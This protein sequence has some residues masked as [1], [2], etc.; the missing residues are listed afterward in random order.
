M[1]IPPAGLPPLPPPRAARS[2]VSCATSTPFFFAMASKAFRKPMMSMFFLVCMT[3]MN[4]TSESAGWNDLSTSPLPLQR[5][6]KAALFI[7]QFPDLTGQKDSNMMVRASRASVWEP[8]AAGRLLGRRAATLTDGRCE[9]GDVRGAVKAARGCPLALSTGTSS[10]PEACA[11]CAANAACAACAASSEFPGGGEPHCKMAFSRTKMLWPF[12]F[13]AWPSALWNC[14]Q[15]MRVWSFTATSS[16]ISPN[17]SAVSTLS[18]RWAAI[19]RSTKPCRSRPGRSR[20]KLLKT[21]RTPSAFIAFV[22][23]PMANWP[24]TRSP[25]T[26]TAL[27]GFASGAGAALATIFWWSC[28]RSTPFFR[29]TKSTSWANCFW[30]T[31]LPC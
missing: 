20:Q 13:A 25:D 7:S 27:S 1:Y 24:M 3:C 8:S 10:A 12:R 15:P 31:R 23:T 28:S 5:C 6:A 4:T 11:A 22:S 26:S 16:N 9:P 14:C 2:R 29:A 18:T 21:S 19:A 30:L 17:F